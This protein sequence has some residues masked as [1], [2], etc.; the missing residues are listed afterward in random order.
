MCVCL[1]L[2]FSWLELPGLFV[3][4]VDMVFGA[5]AVLCC[6]WFWNGIVWGCLLVNVLRCCVVLFIW[7]WC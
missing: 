6:Y 7:G 3:V 5:F 4:V 2:W 1:R